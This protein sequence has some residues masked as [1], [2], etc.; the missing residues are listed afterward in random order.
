MA[1]SGPTAVCPQC[2]RTVSIH[3]NCFQDWVFNRHRVGAMSDRSLDMGELFGGGNRLDH[4]RYP[5]NQIDCP[6]SGQVV[7]S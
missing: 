2:K 6:M 5:S 1:K 4:D 7:G 3:Q